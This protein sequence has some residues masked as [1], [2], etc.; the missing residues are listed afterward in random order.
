MV[1]CWP[2]RTTR[3]RGAVRIETIEPENRRALRVG[4]P[5]R[6]TVGLDG[7]GKP[8]LEPAIGEGQ[9]RKRFPRLRTRRWRGGRTPSRAERVRAVRAR[10]IVHPDTFSGE[11][12][13]S[14]A[15]ISAAPA[16]LHI[17]VPQWFAGDR[18]PPRLHMSV[19]L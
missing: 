4:F 12:F 10:E 8:G 18:T 1:H 17:P 14:Y 13:L 16:L 5:W 19:N 15:P 6:R 3:Q 9:S 11:P 7:P 2:N